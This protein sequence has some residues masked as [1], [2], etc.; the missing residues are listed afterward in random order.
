MK[1]LII[2]CGGE[3]TRFAGLR[4]KWM[5][6][7]PSGKLMITEAIAGIRPGSYD[8]II[9]II[10]RKHYDIYGNTLID[11]LMDEL[12]IS[13]AE[14]EVVVIDSSKNQ[15]DTIYDGLKT[16]EETGD[17]VE[18]QI[19]IKDCD[20]FFEMGEM[21]GNSVAV[22]DISETKSPAN[23]SYVRIGEQNSIVNIVEKQV[24]SNDFCC[25]AY[26]FEDVKDFIAVYEEIRDN[27][28]IYVS[29][30]I[31][32]MILDG[33]CFFTKKAEKYEDWGTVEDWIAYKKT[34]KTLFLDFD[35]VMVKS[36]SGHFPPLWGTTEAIQKNVD[37]INKLYA[38]GRVTVII[39]TARSKKFEHDTVRQI[40]R[41]GLKY[42]MIMMELP[43]A[44]RVIVNDFSDSNPYPSCTAINI[45][46]NANNLDK[47]LDK[48][49]NV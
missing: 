31:Y 7:H 9:V 33:E 28:N 20:N 15:P 27:T 23:K 4:P 2:P 40:H 5:L 18:G 26:S 8:G 19:V 45:V 47:L 29:H 21:E 36:S 24:I 48:T 49:D 1:T 39:T 44:Q 12:K 32:K 37:C 3:S 6:C 46:R 25:G 43:H 13:I 42:H 14:P 34:F 10:L 35:G 11:S 16:L 30:V 22:C 38:S 17:K 41:I